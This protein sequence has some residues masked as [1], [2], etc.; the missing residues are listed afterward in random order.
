MYDDGWGF[1]LGRWS[2]SASSLALRLPPLSPTPWSPPTTGP[3]FVG[4]LVFVGMLALWLAS[5]FY[6][7]DVVFDRQRQRFEQHQE[8][9]QSGLS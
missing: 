7:N 2:S 5:L 6:L 3:E 4:G 9:G 8:R 1:P